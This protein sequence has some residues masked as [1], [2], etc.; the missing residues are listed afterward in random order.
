MSICI[1]VC[2]L[3]IVF[4]SY[5]GS[6]SDFNKPLL[7]VD[8]DTTLSGLLTQDSNN[9]GVSD[10]EESLFGLNPKGDGLSNKKIIDEKRK[11]I[12]E[13]NGL[14][15]NAGLSNTETSKF[16]GQIMS[17]I[18]ALK[19]SGNLTP[20]SVANLTQS[21]GDSVDSKKDSEQRYSISNMVIGG[22]SN[23]DLFSYG[24][25]LEKIMGDAQS[26]G[27][28]KELPEIKNILADSSN[29]GGQITTLDKYSDAYAKFSS[30][31][32]LLKTPKSISQKALAVINGSDLMSKALKKIELTY[33]DAVSGLIG[34]DEYGTAGTAIQ[35][36]IADLLDSM[37]VNPLLK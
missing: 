1:G 10:W 24:H 26:A 7:S 21:L 3:I 37:T 23:E 16:S 12:R 18:L 8:N 25:S 32:L 35:I 27:I 33:S 29:G 17:T 28:G 30:D 2:I 19:Q 4:A 5:F 20:E 9:N 6:N 34:Y 31:L 15:G 36:G 11:K 13:D 14:K 22:D